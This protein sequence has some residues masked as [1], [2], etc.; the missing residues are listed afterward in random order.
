MVIKKRN[1]DAPHRSSRNPEDM[2]KPKGKR[3]IAGKKR[4]VLEAPSESGQERPAK[5]FQRKGNFNPRR[6]GAIEDNGS[7]YR[8]RPAPRRDS[9]SNSGSGYRDKFAPR[10]DSEN[11][12]SYRDRPAPRRDSENG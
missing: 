7:S 3:I 1:Y 10:R 6:E 12:S 8:D 2:P 9:E 5:K 4:R 11:G